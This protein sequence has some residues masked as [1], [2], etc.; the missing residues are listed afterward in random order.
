MHKQ[1]QTAHQVGDLIS[2]YLEA[3]GRKDETAVDRYF[4]PDIE[5][6]VNGVV[7]SDPSSGRP[8]ISPDLEKAFPWFGIHRGRVAVK[9]FLNLLHQNLEVT[10]YGP[11]TVISDGEKAAAF[12]WFRFGFMRCPLGA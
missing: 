8:P 3:V 1:S 10:A 11:R 7:A 9:A 2:Q 4:H 6:I 5:Y 12:G